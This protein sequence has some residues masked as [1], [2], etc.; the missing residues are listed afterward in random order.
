LVNGSVPGNKG[1]IVKIQ[2]AVKVTKW[3]LKLTP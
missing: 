2:S 3:Q 1:N